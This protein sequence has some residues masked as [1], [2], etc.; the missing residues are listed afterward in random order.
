MTASTSELLEPLSRTYGQ[1]H[2]RCLG[3]VNLASIYDHLT[4]QHESHGRH[5]RVLP[6]STKGSKANPKQCIK[7]LSA[8]KQQSRRTEAAQA[9]SHAQR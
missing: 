4:S 9:L 3:L 1:R 6:Y 2:G 8:E 7:P 5:R